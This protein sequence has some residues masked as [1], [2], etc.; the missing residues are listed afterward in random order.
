MATMSD[1]EILERAERAARSVVVPEGRYEDLLRRHDR[2]RRNQRISA[3]AVGIAVVAAVVWI[4]TIGGMFD[5]AQTPGGAEPTGPADRTTTAPAIDTRSPL[6][7]AAPWYSPTATSEVDYVIDL[8]TGEM[9][10]LP[11]AIIRSLGDTGRLPQFRYAASSDGS[12]LA[13]VGTGEEGSPQIFIA[14]IDG[15]GVRQVTHDQTRAT[16]PAWSPDG[17]SIAYVA[18]GDADVPSIYVLD[19]ATGEATRITDGVHSAWTPTFTPDGSSI[20][21]TEGSAPPELR[22]VPLAGGESTLLLG[23][24]DLYDSASGWSSDSANGSMSPDGSLVTFLGTCPEGGGPCR[25]VAN[26]DGTKRR[27]ILG[28]HGVPAGTWSPD[29]SRIVAETKR[30]GENLPLPPTSPN[31]IYVVDVSTKAAT[32]VANGRG[33]IWL[34]DHRLLVEV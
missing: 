21:F 22:T 31:F 20:L 25:Y 29:G 13:F 11:R 2:K 5:P 34:D 3:G 19:V 6:P 4:A 24:G 15:T 16:S 14:G 8:N 12:M 10:P 26:V 18:H 17:T 27:V 33:A 7:T 1:R 9:T 23:P 28:W 32:I 30:K